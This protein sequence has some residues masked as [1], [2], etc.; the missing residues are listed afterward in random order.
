MNRREFLI[1]LIAGTALAQES[2]QE[3]LRKELEEYKEEREGF[4]RYLEEV[5]REFEEYKRITMEEFRR[6]KGEVLRHWDVYEATDRRKI[7]QYSDDFRTKKVFDFK[8]GELR[9]EA[10]ADVEDFNKFL[11]RELEDFISQDERE[12][13]R[14]DKLLRNI[15]RRVRKLKHIKTSRLKSEPVLTPIVFGKEKVSVSE[16]K[17]GVRNLLRRGA[18]ERRSDAKGGY[19]AFVVRFPPKRILEKAR[20]YKPIVVRESDRWRLDY[21]LIFAI[22]HTESYFNPLATSHVPAYGLMQIVPHTAGRDVSEFLFGRPV[23]FAPSYLYNPENNI[24]IGTT[25]VHLLYYKYF[26]GIRN[27]ESRLYCTIAAYNTGP[28]NVARALTGTRSL[29]KASQAANAMGPEDVYR[30]LLKNLPY[31]ETKD[32]L[33]KVSARI[34]VYKNL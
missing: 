32:Y 12:A 29:K 11:K 22:I 8:E 27:P 2:F 25:Y 20:Q 23:L 31:Q 13:F 30:T 24:K 1:G 14:S 16:L 4:D 17:E 33:R 21:P 6:F 18:I 15:E 10:R 28:G 7:V 26:K 19:T 34:S 3:F 9:I 5:N